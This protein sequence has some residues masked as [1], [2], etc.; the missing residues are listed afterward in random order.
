MVIHAIGPHT[1][2][3]RIRRYTCFLFL[4]FCVTRA[5]EWTGPALIGFFLCLRAKA[6]ILSHFSASKWNRVAAFAIGLV[7]SAPPWLLRC[8]VTLLPVLIPF[9]QRLF[10][11]HTVY[12]CHDWPSSFFYPKNRII[13]A[14][15]S[16]LTVSR[17]VI[18]AELDWFTVKTKINVSCRSVTSSAHS[19]Q[20]HVQ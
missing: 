20:Y 7:Y 3:S 11:L 5:R 2:G 8:G 12:T 13:S 19:S 1:P 18:L 14:S 17:P 16:L 4:F 9:C 10:F 15:I 6:S